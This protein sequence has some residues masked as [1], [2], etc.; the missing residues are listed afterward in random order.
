MHDNDKY[1]RAIPLAVCESQCCHY[2]L[3]MGYDEV[4]PGSEIRR[5]FTI[6][7]NVQTQESCMRVKHSDYDIKD[8]ILL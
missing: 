8:A 7:P 1:T 2:S 3:M 4:S 5:L 6:K